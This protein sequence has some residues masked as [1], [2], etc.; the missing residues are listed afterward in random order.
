M[1]FPKGKISVDAAKAI[2]TDV[3][4]TFITIGGSVAGY[5]AKFNG[6]EFEDKSITVLCKKLWQM[7][8][9]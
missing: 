3:E 5:R 6:K 4:F 1:A 9:V 2:F 8:G 7:C